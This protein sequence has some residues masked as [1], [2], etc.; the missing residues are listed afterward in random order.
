MQQ[1]ELCAQDYMIPF[2]T[3]AD[4]CTGP[5]TWKATFSGNVNGNPTNLTGIANSANSR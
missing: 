4:N 1:P 5:L 3:L 2:P